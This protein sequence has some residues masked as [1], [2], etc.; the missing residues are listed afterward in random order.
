[1]NTVF[2]VDD[3]D[4]NL[5][6]AEAAL[7]D[8]YRVMTVPS[9]VKMFNLLEK[10]TPDIILLDIEMPDIDGFTALK[11]L[12]SH[13]TWVRIPVMFL[14]GRSDAEVEVRGFE[15]GAV[16]FL[17]KPF[18]PSVLKNRIKT[19]LNIERII[20][21]RTE[22]LNR[23]QNSI[24]E[25]LADMVE[26]RDK[27]TDGHIERTS[28]FLRILMEGMKERGVYEKEIGTWDVNKM[29]LAARMHDL[30]KISITDL[31]INKPGK[32]TPEEYQIMKTH[33]VEGERIIEEIISR[34]GDSDFLSNAKLFAGYHHER[35]DG[36]GYSRGLKGE[37]IPLQGRIMAIVDVYDALVH[38]RPYKKA[39]TNEV[40]VKMIMENSGTHYDPEIAKVFYELRDQ[41]Q[42]VMAGS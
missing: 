10:I 11:R 23:M 28:I 13:E 17:L 7:E 40:A 30:G 8:Q 26:N 31:I 41:F 36:K 39:F 35:W 37:E 1:M 12:Q 19:H 25:V 14:T 32:L 38:D 22:Q 5:S 33:A 27:G 9:A 29:V 4:T 18:S 21:E 6:M 24:V 16:D 42:A 34:T 3:S 20:R 15:M 2:V